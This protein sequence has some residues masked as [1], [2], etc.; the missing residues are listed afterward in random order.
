MRAGNLNTPAYLLELTPDLCRREI[1]WLWVSIRSKESAEPPAASGLRA[2][3]KVTVRSWWDERLRAGRY[4]QAD[5][6]LL[7]IDDVRDFTGQRAEV[8]ITCSELVGLPAQYL[9]CQGVPVHFRAHLTFEAPYRDELGQVTGYRTR[10]EVALIEVGRPQ[11]DDQLS[12]AGT[13]YTV[14][15]YADDTDDGVVRGLWLEQV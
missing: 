6:R 1:D 15:G 14:I 3:A 10:A 12:I 13:R 9:P 8:V 2:P 11:E 4:L 7:L 5:D